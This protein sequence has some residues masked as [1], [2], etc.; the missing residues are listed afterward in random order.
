MMKPLLALLLVGLLLA[1]TAHAT[2]IVIPKGMTAWHLKSYEVNP[3]ANTLMTRYMYVPVTKQV[4]KNMSLTCIQGTMVKTKSK[5]I[6][7][8]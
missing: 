8:R 2:T 6:C 3:H 5:S 4:P 7:M 1:N